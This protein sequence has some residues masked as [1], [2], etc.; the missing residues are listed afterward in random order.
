VVIAQ[1]V[2]GGFDPVVLAAELH[3]AEAAAQA[4]GIRGA[5]RTPFLLARLAD[6]TRGESLRINQRLIVANADLAAQIAQ[7]LSEETC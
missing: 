6:R 2:K 3:E 1:P 7:C 5:A 4:A